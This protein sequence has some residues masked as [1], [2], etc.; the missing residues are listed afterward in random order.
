MTW[1]RRRG[2]R[3]SRLRISARLRMCIQI[4]MP[5]RIARRRMRCSMPLLVVRC[6][7]GR[8]RIR[9]RLRGVAWRRGRSRRTLRRG[10]I[11]CVRHRRIGRGVPGLRLMRCRLV[12]LG[13]MRRLRW[14]HLLFLPCICFCGELSHYGVR[15]LVQTPPIHDADLAEAVWI[16]GVGEYLFVRP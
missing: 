14:V 2:I 16:F 6:G 1:R 15:E 4:R 11:R 7:R 3:H 5:S 10:H 12:R 9:G 13:L 8:S